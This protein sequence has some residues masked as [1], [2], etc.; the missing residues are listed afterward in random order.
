MLYFQF[1][2][3]HFQFL[4]TSNFYFQLLLP[5]LYFQ[6]YTSSFLLHRVDICN[7]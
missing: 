6:L 5:T 4:I 2:I 7:E 1:S 3:L